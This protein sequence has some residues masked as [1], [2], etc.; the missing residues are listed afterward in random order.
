MFPYDDYPKKC[1]NISNDKASSHLF[2]TTKFDESSLSLGRVRLTALS[3]SLPVVFFC[4][5]LMTINY[6]E[7]VS[8]V[9]S[10]VQSTFLLNFFRWN[11]RIHWYD[12]VQ[13]TF[14]TVTFISLPYGDYLPNPLQPLRGKG[15]GHFFHQ[16]FSDKI[17]VPLGGVRLRA[18]SIFP[19][20]IFQFPLNTFIVYSVAILLHSLMTII[21]KSPTS[22]YVTMVH[23]SFAAH[24]FS[25]NLLHLL[26]E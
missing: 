8:S 14:I 17:A 19:L 4:Y 25:V 24:L 12:W 9:V 3:I 13:G 20:L 22:L 18:V 7:A 11:R 15:S 6:K 5:S 1:Y 10:R 2:I 16:Y 26:G 21:S 23:G